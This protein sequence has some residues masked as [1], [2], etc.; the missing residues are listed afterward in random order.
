ML[1]FSRPISFKP[2]DPLGGGLGEEI[3]AE[4]VEPGAIVLEEGMDGQE[5]SQFW[6]SVKQDVKDDPDWFHFSN[7]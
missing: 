1:F 3:V 5:L 7:D 6:E 4:Q 2:I